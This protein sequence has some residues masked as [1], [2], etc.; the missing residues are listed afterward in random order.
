LTCIEYHERPT[1]PS[2]VMTDRQT[3]LPGADDHRVNCLANVFR[4]SHLTAPS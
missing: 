2:Q 4:H 3:C 1:L